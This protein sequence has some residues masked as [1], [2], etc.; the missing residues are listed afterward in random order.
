MAVTKTL[1]G[2]IPSNKDGKVEVWELTMKYEEGA[3]ATYYTSDM[4]V[5][6]PAIRPAN[7]AVNFIPKA[8][9]E[10]T[11][12]ELTAL[13]PTDLW[14]NTFDRQY[15]S[16]ITNPPNKPVPDPNYVIPS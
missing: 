13:C 10:W 5:S 2:A 6:I 4:N 9:G 15:D 7:G 16:V 12:A 3:D 1:I 14:D 11:L 8:E